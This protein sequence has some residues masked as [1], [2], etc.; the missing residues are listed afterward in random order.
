MIQVKTP[1][2]PYA[3]TNG[4]YWPNGLGTIPL[5][6]NLPDDRRTYI[7]I[8]VANATAGDSL[9][10][11]VFNG[12]DLLGGAVPM[13]AGDEDQSADDIVAQIVTNTAGVFNGTAASNGQVII[14]RDNDG[15]GQW[16]GTTFTATTS[17]GTI[18]NVVETKWVIDEAGT[19]P[20]GTYYILNAF[21]PGVETVEPA[22]TQPSTTQ[23][24]LPSG[25]FPAWSPVSLVPGLWIYVPSTHTLHQIVRQQL[26]G[27][28]GLSATFGT[29]LFVVIEPPLPSTITTPIPFRAMPG[30]V[31]GLRVENSGAAAG[32]FNGQPFPA[33]QV[34]DRSIRPQRLDVPVTYNSTGTAYTIITNP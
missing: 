15:I 14:Y 19:Y 33:D 20:D 25:P 28:S 21:D 12:I 26:M 16:I 31:P 1:V 17:N 6:I 34:F 23:M 3:T 5:P 24:I 29:H 13:V 27:G 7:V 9:D 22:Y 11:L 18:L 10:T 30:P 32:V 4:T 2:P 8:T